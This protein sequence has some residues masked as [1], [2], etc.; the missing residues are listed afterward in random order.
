MAR[1]GQSRNRLVVPPVPPTRKGNRPRSLPRGAEGGRGRA[2]PK[3]TPPPSAAAHPARPSGAQTP[4]G[5]VRR[6]RRPRGTSHIGTS[7]DSFASRSPFHPFPPG[8]PPPRRPGNRMEGGRLSPVDPSHRTLSSRLPWK[9]SRQ[10]PSPVVEGTESGG[11]LLPPLDR[12]GPSFPSQGRDRRK[13]R[14]TPGASRDWL[15]FGAGPV[16]PRLP[17]RT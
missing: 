11:D 6:V 13:S 16:L 14:V 12:M 1:R 3:P 4:G 15:R 7:E 2:G 9:S 10:D 5:T 8:L 17:V